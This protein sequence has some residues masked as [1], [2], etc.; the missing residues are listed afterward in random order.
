[1]VQSNG[2]DWVRHRKLTAPCFSER[3]SATVWS[4]ALEQ[5]EDMVAKWLSS[6]SR[7]NTGIIKDTSTLALNVI[8]SVAFENHQVN[9]P[10]AGHTLSLR[11]SLVTV[12]ST[13]ISPAL[14]DIMPWLKGSSL[15]FL[16]P[17][18]V[19][20]LLVAMTEFRQYMDETIAREREKTVPSE[21][22]RGHLNLSSTLIRA[23][24]EANTN[25]NHGEETT[26]PRL[27]DVELRAN[28]F[29]FTAGGLE[30]TSITL[31]YALAL[32]AVHPDVQKWVVEEIDEVLGNAGEAEY[33]KVFPK[34]KRLT[35]RS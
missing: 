20:K 30:T 10:T 17:T 1:M 26:K 6:P 35:T 32:L 9:K 4:E 33:S 24:D 7:D 18:S 2:D 13:S 34:L 8:S 25:T 11:D 29:I 16:F 12:M 21:E 15:K 19:K 31:S 3:A 27:S 5:S 14:E 23:N 28:I 22:P